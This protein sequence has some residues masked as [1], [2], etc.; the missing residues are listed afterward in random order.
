MD[1]V[2]TVEQEAGLHARP[3]AQFVET[4]NQ[5]ESEITVAPVDGTSGASGASG[6]DAADDSSSAAS[7]VDAG[8]MLA[9]TGLGV[10]HGDRVR[11]TAEGPDAEAAL[12]ELAALLSRPEP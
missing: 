9:V 3:A 4:A 8:S 5:Y 11:L 2:V 12:D 7:A 6:N 1:R 10:E